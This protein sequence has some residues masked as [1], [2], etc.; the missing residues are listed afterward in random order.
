MEKKELSGEKRKENESNLYRRRQKKKI[1]FGE[2]NEKK[3]ENEILSQCLVVVY[4][5]PLEQINMR[6]KML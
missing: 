1:R 2:K 5:L 3:I 6:G 4:C